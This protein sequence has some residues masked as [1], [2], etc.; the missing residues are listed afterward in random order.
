MS[1]KQKFPPNLLAVLESLKSEIMKE[2]NCVQIGTIESFDT[3]DQTASI[4]MNIKK[5]ISVNADGSNVLEDRP[6]LVRCP[7]VILGGGSSHMTFDIKK[8]DSCIIFFNDRDIDNWFFDGGQS[9]PNSVRTH[10]LSDGIA[11]VGVRNMQNKILDFFEDGIRI[12]FDETNKIEMSEDLTRSIVAIFWQIGAMVITGGLQIGGI[13]T[14]YT[15]GG[16]LDKLIIHSDIEHTE[17]FINTG[18]IEAGNGWTGTFATGDSRICTVS[19][20]IVT[21]VS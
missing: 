6:L 1:D 2:I 16:G 19:K 20:G 3:T 13:V 7:C 17:D 10:D 11:L 18:I 12:K 14:A 21:D 9:P 8:G 5:I 15:G 4:S